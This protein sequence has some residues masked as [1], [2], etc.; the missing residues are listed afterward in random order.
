MAKTFKLAL[1]AGHYINT[2]GRRCLKQYDPLEHREWWLNARVCEYI[3][4]RAAKYEGFEVLRVDDRT[5]QTEPSLNQRCTAANQWG[6]DLYYSA[7][8][9]AGINGGSGG[10]VTAYSYPSSTKGAQW[11]DELYAAVIAAGKLKGNRA[12][13]KHEKRFTVLC[14]TN[15]PA[16][17]IEH[18]FMDSSTDIPI[19]ISED[20]ARAVGY[21]VADHIAQRAGLTKRGNQVEGAAG[22]AP[23][24]FQQMLNIYIKTL[25]DNDASAWSEE[26]RDWAIENGLVVG[27]GAL[28][29]GEINYAWEAPITR[30]QMVTLL[31]RFSK[32]N[33]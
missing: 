8:H 11:R 3:E 5:G 31:Y 20:Y 28:P 25:Q 17:L 14:N 10:G 24:E 27:V 22:T 29:D 7:H 1:D 15:M 18:G 33:E 4:E 9:N 30:E 13:P 23:N 26:A 6:A 16:V 21:A 12:M 19:I 32:I 2:P